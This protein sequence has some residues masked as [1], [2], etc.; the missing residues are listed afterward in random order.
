[1]TWLFNFSPLLMIVFL[2]L[3]LD[4]ADKHASRPAV[5]PDA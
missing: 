5:N 3:V 1:M 2:M 4:W